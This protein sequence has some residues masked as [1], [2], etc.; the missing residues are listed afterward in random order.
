MQWGF[1]PGQN[2]S[3]HFLKLTPCAGEKV[4]MYEA[5]LVEFKIDA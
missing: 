2:V 1:N 4:N 3:T 5:L